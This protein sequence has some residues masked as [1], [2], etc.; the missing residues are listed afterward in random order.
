MA[1][2]L[3]KPCSVEKRDNFIA[4]YNQNC[5]QNRNYILEIYETENA[6][7]ALEPNEIILNG[8]IVINPQY[9]IQTK[10]QDLKD[11]SL[12]LQFQLKELD[13]KT[14]R[15]MREGGTMND[16]TPYLDYYLAQINKLRVE[17]TKIIEEQNNLEKEL[18][19]IIN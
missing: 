11:K 15:A 17:L 7:F 10:I 3:E 19:D 13:F 9:E 4:E 16:G 14:I 2:K 6:I 18:N 12:K 5:H 1:Y 8:E